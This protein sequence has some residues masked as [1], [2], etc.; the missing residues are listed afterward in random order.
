MDCE[1]LAKVYINLIDQKEPIF[2]FNKIKDKDEIKIVTS[3][4]Y[5]K[6]IISASKEEIEIHKSFLNKE[7]KK[8]YY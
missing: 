6:K 4:N 1:L 2:Q 8:N 5:S 7:I 3:K